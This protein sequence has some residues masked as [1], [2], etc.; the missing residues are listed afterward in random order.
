M[1]MI[2]LRYG[3]TNTYYVDGLLIDTDMPGTITGF[4]RELKRNAID[5]KDIRYV[6]ATHYHPDHMGLI[7]ELMSFGVKLLLIDRQAESVHFS[8][9]VFEKQKNLKYQPIREK[10]AV[11]ISCEDSRQFLKEIGIDGEIIATDSHSPDGIALITD[12]GICFAGDLEPL[13]FIDAY[14]NNTLLKK[15]LGGYSELSSQNRLFW[16]CERPVF[17]TRSRY[18]DCQQTVHSNFASQYTKK[19]SPI[20]R[21]LIG[22]FS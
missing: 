16:A 9:S 12:D 20:S 6:L 18:K 8:D 21:N 13:P 5:M 7:S 4:F 11:V 19:K 15:R 22:D 1:K 2:K 17:L 3:N 14:E 10:D